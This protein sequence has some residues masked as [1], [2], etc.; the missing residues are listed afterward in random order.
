MSQHQPRRMA[1]PWRQRYEV[2]LAAGGGVPALTVAFTRKLQDLA[3]LDAPHYAILEVNDDERGMFFGQAAIEGD[4]LLV[5]VMSPSFAAELPAAVTAARHRTLKQ[6]GWEP[7]SHENDPNY[8]LDTTDPAEH[9]GLVEHLIEAMV[10][11][12]GLDDADHVELTT[13]PA[14]RQGE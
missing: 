8:S 6:L 4:D 5:E 14:N 2:P 3:R 7:P 12:Y 1:R 13:F 11:A 10:A 9:G